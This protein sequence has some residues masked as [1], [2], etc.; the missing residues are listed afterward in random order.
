[1]AWFRDLSM[2]SSEALHP[3]QGGLSYELKGLVYFEI[4]FCFSLDTVRL[5][6]ITITVTM[7]RK[8][9]VETV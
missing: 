5:T 9:L 7:S 6:N 1:M 4:S 3:A 8:S 2:L